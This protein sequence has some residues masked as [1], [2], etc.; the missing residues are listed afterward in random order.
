M[1]QNGKQGRASHAR[2][3]ADTEYSSDLMNFDYSLDSEEFE[4]LFNRSKLFGKFPQCC[5]DFAS[6]EVLRWSAIA[7]LR[8]SFRTICCERG[9]NSKEMPSGAWEKWHAGLMANSSSDMDPLIPN[10][11][12]KDASV[13]KLL[14]DVIRGELLKAGLDEKSAVGASTCLDAAATGAA[15]S[16]IENIRK[17]H[18]TAKSSDHEIE[19]EIKV[20]HVDHMSIAL[21]LSA[22]SDR[23]SGP[24]LR[25]T[26]AHYEKLRWLW[27]F[28]HNHRRQL[29]GLRRS[30][31][32]HGCSARLGEIPQKDLAEFHRSFSPV[33]FI[34]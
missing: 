27:A 20:R 23:P 8:D 12:Q 5:E 14:S 28:N 6:I 34:Q 31:E 18:S 19:P 15:V 25:V 2:K 13:K 4:N 22:T 29:A 32:S 16:F 17:L 24:E 9:L 30:K 10:L 11:S 26:P 21:T 3:L 1:I 7:S 33:Q